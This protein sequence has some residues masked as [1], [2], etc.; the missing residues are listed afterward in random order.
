MLELV[1]V[2]R[3]ILH[4]NKGQPNGDLV[5]VF[6]SFSSASC[7]DPPLASVLLQSAKAF[8]NMP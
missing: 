8:Q 4:T 3:Q 5:S 1:L 6:L 7:Q 2:S